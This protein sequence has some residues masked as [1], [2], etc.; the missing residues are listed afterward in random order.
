MNLLLTSVGRRPYLVRWFLEALECAGVGGELFIADSD[1]WAPARGMGGKFILAPKITSEGYASWLAS[2]LESYSIDLAVSINDFELS[3]WASLPESSQ[4]DPLMRLEKPLQKI[5]EDKY[6]L[7]TTLAKHGVAVPPTWLGHQFDVDLTNRDD[8]ITKG[9]Y[10]S[11]SRGLRYADRTNIEDAIREASKEVTTQFGGPALEQSEIDPKSLVVVQ[12]RITGQEYGL[13]IVCDFNGSFA[14]VLARKKLVM[15]GGE[16]DRAITVDP[17]QFE[18][19]ASKV[20]NAVPHQGTFDVDVIVDSSGRQFVIDVNPRFGGG[21]P[22]SHVAGANIPRAYIAW[23][24][25]GQADPNSLVTRIGVAASK[26][27]EV[28]GLDVGEIA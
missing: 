27:V 3:R 22:L 20:S 7:T 6:D 19:L 18:D 12:E 4:W 5:V 14:G 28:I 9:R 25:G 16:T 15:R 17:V 8:F 11:A 13:D 10:G 1:P 2:I 24:L 21:Y 23:A 26:Y